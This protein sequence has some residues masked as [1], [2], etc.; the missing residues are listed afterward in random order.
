LPLNF[1]VGQQVRH[2]RYGRGTITEVGGFG[3]RRTVRVLFPDDNRTETF[4]AS[5]APLQPIG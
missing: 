1:Q 2:P 5:K 4:V 3:P